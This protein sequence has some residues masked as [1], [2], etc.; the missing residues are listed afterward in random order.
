MKL[1]KARRLRDFLL[2]AGFIVMLCAYIWEPLLIV[3][4]IISVSCLIPHFL[5]NRCPHCRKQLGNNA[6]K[7]CQH[8]GKSLD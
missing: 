7:Y 3:G 1:K 4:A 8:C 5:F 6:A 2:I